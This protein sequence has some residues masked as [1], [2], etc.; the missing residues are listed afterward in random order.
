M[1]SSVIGFLRK[2]VLSRRAP[3]GDPASFKIAFQCQ[4]GCQH[5]EKQASFEIAFRC[6]LEALSDEK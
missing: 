5:R 3:K 6:R 4:M 2:N 1:P